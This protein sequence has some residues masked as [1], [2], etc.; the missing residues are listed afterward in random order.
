MLSKHKNHTAGECK[1]QNRA[2]VGRAEMPL[3]KISKQADDGPAYTIAKQSQ[4]NNHISEVMPLNNGKKPH[5]QDFIGKS[6]G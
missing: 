5:Q 1:Q 3:E 2:D 4:A 6:T